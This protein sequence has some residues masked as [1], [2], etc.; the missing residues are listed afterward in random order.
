MARRPD[1]PCAVC[2]RLLWRGRTSLPE[3]EA[4]CRPCRADRGPAHGR[5]GTYRDGCRCEAC[6]EWKRADNAQ[7]REPRPRVIVQCATCG[8][9]VERVARNIDGDSFCDRACRL[10]DPSR[11][12]ERKAAKRRA[13]AFRQRAERVAAKAAAGTSGA[14]TWTAGQCAEC[15]DHFIRKGTPSPYCGKKCSRK[16]RMRQ[17]RARE[18]GAKI[19]PARR[20]AI[21]ERDDWTCQLCGDPVNRDA[22]VPALDAPVLDHVLALAAGGEHSEDNLQTAHFYCNSVKRDL[23]WEDTA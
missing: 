13:L 6:R 17:R 20:H 8:A 19:T 23:P 11:R 18:V 14:S 16:E 12:A 9:D 7:R 4:T 15:G 5:P 22:V 1:L 21:H 10:G 2:G 3:G